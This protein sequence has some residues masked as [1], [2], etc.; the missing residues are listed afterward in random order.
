[1]SYLEDSIDWRAIH[2]IDIWLDEGVGPLYQ[3]QPFAQDWA[4]VGKLAEELGEAMENMP[5]SATEQ[6]YKRAAAISVALGKAIQ[7][8]ISFTGQ[9][10]RKPQRPEGFTEMLDELADTVITGILAIQ[11]FTKDAQ[12]TRDL[13][14]GKLARIEQRARAAREVVPNA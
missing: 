8:L 13:V 6:D 7:A 12:T 2:D 14:R 5:A 10:P 4:R 9:N 11:H 1:M 3:Q